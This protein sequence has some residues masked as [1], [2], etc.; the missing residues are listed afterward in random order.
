M[1]PIQYEV[2]VDNLPGFHVDAV[3][4]NTAYEILLET[5]DARR[6]R[7]ALM[8]LASVASSSDLRQAV[9]VLEEPEISIQRLLKE[10]EGAISVIRP[11]LSR[12]LSLFFRRSGE[13]SGTPT[14]PKNDEIQL[15]EEIVRHETSRR[16]IGV[17]R[18]T[19]AHYEILRILIHQWLLN[20]GPI[21]INCLMEMAGSSHPT[22]SRSLERLEHYLKRY[23]DRSIE[24]R[25]FP[26]DEW[27]RLL[28]VSDDVRGTV[29]F[30]DRSGHARSPESLLHRLRLLQRK[31]I[32]LG[33]TL[34]AKH[35]LPS[36]DLVGNPRLDISIHTGRKAL[37]LS[38]VKR[39]DPALEKITRRD[40]TPTLV[41]HTIRRAES[42]FEPDGSEIPWADPVECL[43]DLHEARLESQALE[44]INSF[45]TTK[46]HPL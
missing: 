38:F 34:G 18:N 27:G 15:L 39:L 5:K 12:R 17:S 23:S 2:P 14:T 28:A 1:K 36:L 46:N 29:R 44:F 16:P 8:E 22:V 9:L 4:G 11:E 3:S 37:D 43:L 30:T 32:A 45:P 40:E 13:W 24:L 25:I 26:K 35:Y 41:I 20:R 10:W 31:D 42:L 33:G 7:T 6:L 21:S 19:E